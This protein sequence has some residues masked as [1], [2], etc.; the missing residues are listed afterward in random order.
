MSRCLTSLVLLVSVPAIAGERLDNGIE[1]PDTWPPRREHLPQRLPKPPYLTSPPDVVS[2]DVGRQLFVDDFLIEQTTMTRRF[3]QAKYHPANPVLTYDRSWELSKAQG[4][5]PTAC[6]YSG[7]IWYDPA[8]KKFRMW[9]MG[10]YIEHLCLAESEDGIRWTKPNL[11]VKSGTNIV[12]WKGATESNSLLMDLNAAD[13][14]QRFKYF[15]T[16]IGK[17]W[18]TEYRHSPDGIH[19]SELV[20]YSGPHGDRTTVFFNPF[21]KRWVFALRTADRSGARL[22][23][24]KKYW[25]TPDITD[26]A[27]VQWPASAP[28]Q[29]EADAPL[30]VTADRGLDRPRTEIG[31]AP[32]LY[33]LDAVAYE[34]LM[35]GY[36]SI[37]RGDFHENDGDGRDAYPGRPKCAEVCLGFSRDGFHWHRPTHE[38]FM[39]I[40]ETPGDWNW[41]NVQSA[42][43]TMVV[44]GDHL[45]FY[46]SGRRGAGG[47]TAKDS[48]LLHPAYA[49]CSTGLA[50]LRRDG[51]ASMDA[52]S[53][54]T[55]TTR[56]LKFSGSQ[57]FVNTDA[58]EGE[59]RVEMLDENLKPIHPFTKD[60]CIPIKRNKTLQQVTWQG[61]AD[62]SAYAGKTVR[63]RFHL[64]NGSLYSFWVSPDSS[65][66]SNGFVAGGG[67]GFSAHHD[68]VGRKSYRG[69]VASYKQLVHEVLKPAPNPSTGVL[70]QES[71]IMW[72]K[73]DSLKTSDSQAPISSWQ[74]SS[75]N[76]MHAAQTESKSQPKW[77]A[78]SINNQPAL[79]FDGTD[80]H[81]L[82]DHYA[83]VF[84]TFYKSTIFAVVKPASG[85]TILSQAHSYLAFQP[86]RGGQLSFG[87]GFSSS[88]GKYHWPGVSTGLIPPTKRKN[89]QSPMLCA[90]GRS[91]D[92]TGQTSLRINGI[93]ADYGKSAIPYHR[94]SPIEAFVGCAYRKHSFWA[95]D[96]AEIIVYGRALSEGERNSVEAYLGQKYQIT[97]GN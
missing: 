40:S 50:V 37:L 32:Q 48:E 39:G 95:G 7:G 19:W 16:N 83:G 55:L 64:T 24:S 82:L 85:G 12:L 27:T 91:G 11:D 60:A 3:H 94:T 59:L 90:L 42:G 84:H 14:R 65:G 66:A 30:W 25:E 46:V 72:L 69:G 18:K 9:Y 56:K 62:L 38:T 63:F 8:V 10:G 78:K 81:L 76:G 97:I 31:I 53:P 87:S 35:L 34:S 5:L 58:A 6:P 80:D 47:N 89:A 67:P 4:G 49:G 45:Y 43:N 61:A 41:G 36:F 74:D 77:I 57:L 21:R 23:R 44:V 79:R 13:P 33:H 68:N 92:Q 2:I 1:L 73:A 17:G 28:G 71:L 75:K 26:A 52:T 93:R 20:W 29:F 70:P 15:M 51:F 96:I 22:G 88:D 54:T 86:N